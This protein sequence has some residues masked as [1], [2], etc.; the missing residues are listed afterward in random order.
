MEEYTETLYTLGSDEAGNRITAE[1][2][3]NRMTGRRQQVIDMGRLMAELTIPSVFPPDGYEPGDHLEG[4]NQSL[5]AQLVN[6]LAS[7]LMFMAFPPGQP[8]MRIEAIEYMVQEE[9]DKDPELWAKTQLALSRLEIAHRKRLQTT[10][11][12]TAYTGYLKVL[13]V[14]GN[15]LW[16]QLNLEEPTYFL[17]D[18]YVVKRNTGGMPLLT[19]HKEVV[20]LQSLDKDV[21][22]LIMSDAVE[23]DKYR[24]MNEWER[25]ADIYSVCKLKVGHNS[26]EKTWCYWQE[27]KGHTIPGTEVETDFE[28]PPMYPGWLIPVYGK[29]WGRSYCEEYRGDLFT[30]E[31]HASAVNDGASLAALALLF[32]QPGSTTSI[33]QIREA[34][35]LSTLPGNAEDLSVFRS[36][37]TADLSFV[38]SNMDAVGRRLAAVFLLAQSIQRAGERVTA[39][40]IRRMGQALDRAMGGLYTVIAQGNQRWII[41]RAVRLNEEENPDLP[42]LPK[43]VVQVQVVTGIDAMGQTSEAENLMEYGRAGKEIF[44][45][46]FEQAHDASDFFTRLASA[47]GIKPDGLVKKKEQLEADQQAMQQQALTQSLVDKGTGPAVKGMADAAMA[48]Q[49]TPPAQ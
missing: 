43:D 17:P 29:D 6:T 48:S 31:S 19:I 7:A 18:T 25:T 39:E 3:Y 4:N 27:W 46:Q 47:M 21:R 11:I 33:K 10:T 41:M 22:D 32:V 42:S 26:G 44:L 9:V 36:D 24:K 35:N 8:I 13:L 5:S 16:K 23:A 14:A 38:V 49:T 15:A 45:D 28:N 2:S 20:S 37:K 1:D 12:S 34:R 30:L 40:E